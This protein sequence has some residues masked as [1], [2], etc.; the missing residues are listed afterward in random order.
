MAFKLGR[1]L[2]FFADLLLWSEEGFIP[3]FRCHKVR[4]LVMLLDGQQQLAGKKLPDLGVG[5]LGQRFGEREDG[6]F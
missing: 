1:Q 5:G 4:Q 6:E 3:V 2:Q